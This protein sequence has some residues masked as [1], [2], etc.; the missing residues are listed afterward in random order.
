MPTVESRLALV[1]SL[2]LALGGAAA[3]SDQGGGEP[4]EVEAGWSGTFEHD[5]VA[6]GDACE[7]P[8]FPCE[9]GSYCEIV[10]VPE[11]APS[12]EGVGRCV[13]QPTECADASEAW[14][15]GCD[16]QLYASPC[17]AAMIGINVDF[18]A[19]CQAPAGLF[20]CGG[21]FCSIEQ[22]YCEHVWGHG[23]PETW[24]CRLLSCAPGQSGCDCVSSAPCGDPY[25]FPGQWCEALDDGGTQVQCVPA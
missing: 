21:Q 19:S 9:A 16:G 7:L 14:T 2:L 20:P 25:F 6:V 23:S 12:C 10:R 3:C 15:C 4:A 13:E 17:A 22:Q 18:A 24:A 8:W 5:R 11:L 1:A